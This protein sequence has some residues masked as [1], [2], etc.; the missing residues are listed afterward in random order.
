M[1]ISLTEDALKY[2]SDEMKEKQDVAVGLCA[3]QRIG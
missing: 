2:V 1:E 3:V